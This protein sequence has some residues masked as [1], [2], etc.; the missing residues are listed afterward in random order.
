MMTHL[1]LLVAFCG[2]VLGDADSPPLQS[3]FSEMMI[4]REARSARTSS[5][6]RSGGNQDWL[7]I[8]P[9]QTA[10]LAEIEGAG[11]IKH[12][13]WTYIIGDETARRALFRDLIVRMYW[14]GEQTPSVESP[15]GDL[16][17]VG[18]CRPRPLQSLLLVTNPGGASS[19]NSWGLNCYF[20]MP[21]SQGARV[22]VA[23]ESDIPLGI[24][25]HVDY[26]TYPGDTPEG[27]DSL[28][29]FHAQFRRSRTPPIGE[30]GGINKTGEDNYVILEAQGQGNLAG[31]ILNVDNVTGGW[32]GEGDDM[33]FIDG[34]QWPPSLHGTGSEEI[35]GAGAG[36]SVEYTGP[37]TGFHLVE[38]R[39]QD[40]YYGKNSMY[41]F[42]VPDP[43]RFSRSIRVTI[44]HGHANDLP[45]D[46]S[47]VAYWYQREPHAPFPPL[48]SREERQPIT[49]Y[50]GFP[51]IAGAIEGELLLE[52]AESSGDGAVPLR[53]PGEWSRGRFLWFTPDAVGDFITV[54]VPVEAAGTYEVVLY[55]VQASDFGIFQL[56]IDGQD[57]G[58]PFDGYNAEGGIGATHVVRAEAV[59]FGRVS[60]E[61]GT[62][63]F[64]FEIVG[65]N[66]Q[67]TSYMV[68]LDCIVLRPV[69]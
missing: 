16:F 5:Y 28:G 54:K 55:L 14:D 1:L 36:P 59:E 2:S 41:R 39:E 9:G 35:F 46:Y 62:R 10:A 61:A 64:R 49:E 67:A 24:W 56:E 43:I 20:P 60:L 3:P 18:N 65:K 17:G 19:D 45:N 63:E 15:I 69:E 53:F 22:E 48:P 44:E 23:N 27:L 52:D 34:E 47:S 38:N 50:P 58:E 29:R 6:D 11:C 4:L 7:T 42:F 32:W 33:I 57:Q 40:T 31:Y 8:P 13:Y 37:Y 66:D 51:G 25:Y 26:E 30:P 12:I 21:F 68:G